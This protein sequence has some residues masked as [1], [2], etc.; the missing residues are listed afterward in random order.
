MVFPSES[1]GFF[2]A[3]P[4][5]FSS[6]L[7]MPTFPVYFVLFCGI[8][9]RETVNFQYFPFFHVRPPGCKQNE[10]IQDYI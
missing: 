10:V 3:F 9:G 2:L 8:F 5:L 4:V 6:W 7:K 1:P